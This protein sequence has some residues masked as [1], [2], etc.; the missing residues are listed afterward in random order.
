[1]A[2]IKLPP[3]LRSANFIIFGLITLMMPSLG[4]AFGVQN[5]STFAKRGKGQW[6][7]AARANALCMVVRSAAWEP[8][9]GDHVAHV[10]ASFPPSKESQAD[11]AQ[12]PGATPVHVRIFQS[13]W[14]K[15]G[16]WDYEPLGSGQACKIYGCCQLP[17]GYELARVPGH[18]TI[19][20]PTTELPCISVVGTYDLLKILIALAQMV[21]AVL[22]LYEARG[23]QIKRFGYAAFGLTVAPYAVMSFFNL[24]SGLVSPEF[25]L[26]YMVES[27]VMAEARIRP[28]AFF[29]GMV[30]RVVEDEGAEIKIIGKQPYLNALTRPVAFQDDGAGSLSIVS[31]GDTVLTEEQ[32]KELPGKAF[33]QSETATPEQIVLLRQLR[34]APRGNVVNDPNT[35]SILFVPWCP[36]LRCTGDVG[37]GQEYSAE[38]A[39]WHAGLRSWVVVFKEEARAARKVIVAVRITVLAV[40][41]AQIAIVGG[42]SGFRAGSSTLAQR[43]W[44]MAWLGTGQAFA[45]M[46]LL[47]MKFL[48]RIEAALGDNTLFVF[49]FGAVVCSVPAIGG[50][51]VVGQMIHGYGICSQIE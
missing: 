9:A 50:F 45:I 5:M 27:S 8:A 10:L 29:E 12:Q 51:V 49:L 20:H 39:G 11:E 36:P 13:N 6:H 35:E 1:V 18:A 33:S 47:W 32:A 2:T 40:I 43:A 37:A 21:Y 25:P 38:Q 48:D 22:T 17:E 24:A 19:E 41:A 30:G 15:A 7:S 42:L 14:R 16:V 23:D 3:G 34:M 4:L 46:Y 31:G 28:G 44:I 26:M